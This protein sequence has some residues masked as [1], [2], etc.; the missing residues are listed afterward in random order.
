MAE[1]G[2]G[3]EKGAAGER[4]ERKDEKETDCRSDSINSPDYLSQPPL[5]FHYYQS[6]S[7]TL[8][9]FFLLINNNKGTDRN[10]T[11]ILRQKEN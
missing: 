5:I 9:A 8:V 4:K 7:F 1:R 2:L 3:E 10:T 6:F 11:E